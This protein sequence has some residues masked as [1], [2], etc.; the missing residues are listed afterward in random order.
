MDIIETLSLVVQANTILALFLIF[1]GV[2]LEGEIV[3]ITTGVF[4]HLGALDIFQAL[5]ILIIASIVK[6]FFWYTI[7]KKIYKKYG[8][9]KFLRW[10]EQVVLKV[11]PH[12][13]RHPSI[14]IFISKFIYGV[15]HFVIIFSGFTQIRFKTF[16]VAEIISSIPWV[17]VFFG[18]G[19]IFSYTAFSVSKDITHIALVIGL[20]VVLILILSRGL[21]R[22]FNKLEKKYFHE[23]D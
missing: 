17:L 1:L 7:G 22:I 23:T 2:I 14:S 3:L 8:E 20:G 11:L 4:T 18:I 19:Y 16:V 15:N 9:T 5:I 13:P 21:K 6:T 10:V 12:F